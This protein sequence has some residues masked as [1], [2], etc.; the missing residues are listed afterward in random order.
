M[1]HLY[2]ITVKEMSNPLVPDWWRVGAIVYPVQGFFGR[3]LEVCPS[4]YVHAYPSKELAL[5]DLQL[6]SQYVD[7]KFKVVHFKKMAR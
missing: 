2:V 3:R 5:A 4:G 7:I 6:G 1:N